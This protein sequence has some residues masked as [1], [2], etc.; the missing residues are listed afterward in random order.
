MLAQITNEMLRLGSTVV[1]LLILV[2]GVKVQI[3]TRSNQ[4]YFEKKPESVIYVVL[5]Y[6]F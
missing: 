1:K 2:R 6:L 4:F 3:Q 5:T